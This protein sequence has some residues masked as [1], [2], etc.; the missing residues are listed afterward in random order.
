MSII[1][2]LSTRLVPKIRVGEIH[3][4]TPIVIAE[5]YKG[6]VD[7]AG[8]RSPRKLGGTLL[9]AP[10]G[11]AFKTSS[12]PL[13]PFC[14]QTLTGQIEQTLTLLGFLKLVLGPLLGLEELVDALRLAG[15]GG[16]L[17]VRRLLG[18]WDATGL[19]IFKEIST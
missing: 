17:Q 3:P 9:P 14:D 6:V 7:T 13:L 19:F 5:T 15:H 2:S 8:P 11:Y 1:I 4:H 18:L 10:E 12:S 16:Q